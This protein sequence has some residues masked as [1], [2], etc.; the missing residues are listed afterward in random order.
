MAQQPIQPVSR[1]LLYVSM[2][3]VLTAIFI[4]AYRDAPPIYL[5]VGFIGEIVLMSTAH[6]SSVVQHYGAGGP[7]DDRKAPGVADR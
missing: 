1:R 4:G 5:A 3:I 7:T 2:V 6:L